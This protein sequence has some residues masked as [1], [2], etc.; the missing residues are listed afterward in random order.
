MTGTL[1]VFLTNKHLPFNPSSLALFDVLGREVAT[2]IDEF[3]Y[4]GMHTIDWQAE[5]LSTGLSFYKLTAE[6]YTEIKK[7]TLIR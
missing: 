6:N 5:G 7:L 2:L 3:R 4:G 1:C